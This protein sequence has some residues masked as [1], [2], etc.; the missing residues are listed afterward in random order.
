M[1]L[2]LT[3]QS[4]LQKSSTSQMQ[5]R[6]LLSPPKGKLIPVK[7]NGGSD[8]ASG[9]MTRAKTVES[10]QNFFNRRTFSK[11][12]VSSIA[13]ANYESNFEEEYDEESSSNHSD[14]VVL[15]E[16]DNT[17]LDDYLLGSTKNVR[18]AIT[19]KSNHVQVTD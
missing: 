4:K 13:E 18:T 1:S 9:Q 12:R 17:Y 3:E 16:G 15:E 2:L 14:I 10:S 6:S 5:R 19:H 11:K 8:Y 7:A